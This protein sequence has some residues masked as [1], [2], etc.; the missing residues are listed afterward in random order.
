MG[1]RR[2]LANPASVPKSCNFG[3]WSPSVPN[4]CPFAEAVS[5]P[6]GFARE[7]RIAESGLTRDEDEAA[8]RVLEGDLQ[9]TKEIVAPSAAG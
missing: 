6:D 4:P 8:A 3:S 2:T 1:M 9:L 7:R 5:G